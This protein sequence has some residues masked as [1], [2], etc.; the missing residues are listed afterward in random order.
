MHY[1][2]GT[3]LAGKCHFHTRLIGMADAHERYAYIQR[4]CTMYQEWLGD[5]LNRLATEPLRQVDWTAQLTAVYTMAQSRHSSDYDHG[6]ELQMH[7]FARILAHAMCLRDPIPRTTVRAIVV[8]LFETALQC[9]A[10]TVRGAKEGLLRDNL[11]HLLWPAWPDFARLCRGN[12][13]FMRE[14]LLGALT[15]KDYAAV[16]GILN[17]IGATIDSLDAYIMRAPLLT[18]MRDTTGQPEVRQLALRVSQAYRLS[19]KHSSRA[20]LHGTQNALQRQVSVALDA[21]AV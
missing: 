13:I 3:W 16:S 20:R 11:L 12:V 5:L 8:G 4:Q 1:K 6:S 17:H 15:A 10:A 21:F 18:V 14:C 7:C 2:R 19:L 9:D